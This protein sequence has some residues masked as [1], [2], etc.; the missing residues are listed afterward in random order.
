[1]IYR[2]ITLGSDIPVFK[3]S[4]DF[5]LQKSTMQSIWT[6]VPAFLVFIA[7]RYFYKQEVHFLPFVHGANAPFLDILG[8]AFG[9]AGNVTYDYV[10][11]GAGAA[12]SA[13]AAR[14]AEAQHSVAVVEAGG[15][16]Q[17]INGNRSVIPQYA[18]FKFPV[19]Y[20][21]V[22]DWHF[23]SVPQKGLKGRTVPYPRGQA[24]GG[25]TAINF[26]IHTR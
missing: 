7:S 25:S 18:N 5:R 10:V 23:W 19:Y 24:L 6:L 2:D 16:Y 20:S 17:I 21:P 13:I 8:S 3:Q 9:V 4:I 15:F 14:L 1:M 12:G 22:T 26:L 11:V